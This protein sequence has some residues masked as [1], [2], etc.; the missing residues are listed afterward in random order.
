MARDLDAEIIRDYRRQPGTDRPDRRQ[1]I[2]AWSM[3]SGAWRENDGPTVNGMFAAAEWTLGLTDSRP[4]AEVLY[5]DSERLD[6]A[7]AD[8]GEVDLP[9][10]YA[11]GLAE[12][13]LIRQVLPAARPGVKAY[14]QGVYAWLGW[15]IGEQ[16]YPGWITE[17]ERAIA[18]RA[19]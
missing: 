12:V 8:D 10:D 17:E 11:A 18:R 7:L 13:L 3:V 9:Y 16:E 2:L 1:A 6:H 19:S 15:W 14:G 5:T 4:M